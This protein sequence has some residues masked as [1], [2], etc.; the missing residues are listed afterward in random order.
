MSQFVFPP[1]ELVG[2][3]FDA[4]AIPTR[5]ARTYA[6]RALRRF[7]GLLIFARPGDK[8]PGARRGPPLRFVVPYE[9]IHVYQPDNIT[10]AGLPGIGIRPAR[11][12]H[13]AYGLGPAQE[14][15]GTAD[16]YGPGTFL[17]RKS[18]WVEQ[19]AIEVLGAED[20][21]RTALKAGLEEAL[22]NGEDSY[23]LQLRL[24]AY[25]NQVATFASD[26]GEVLEDDPVFRN[27]RRADLYVTM[28][29]PE[30]A[31]VRAPDFDP[32]VVVEVTAEARAVA[33][34]TSA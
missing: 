2:D 3:Q 27:R 34:K 8:P 31:L 17:I 18:D 32:S 21:M 1:P 19:I 30:V 10:D 6:L 4:A 14:I 33:S 16:V 15:D 20:A 26:E 9:N 23:A 29:V 22:T 7:M 12:R 25:Y 5:D 28:T 13:E 11:G 24:P